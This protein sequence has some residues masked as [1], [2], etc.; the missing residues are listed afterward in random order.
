MRLLNGGMISYHTPVFLKLMFASPCHVKVAISFLDEKPELLYQLDCKTLNLIIQL[1]SKNGMTG[2]ARSI[3]G[4]VQKRGLVINDA[5]YES[6]ILGFCKEKNLKGMWE[7]LELLKQ[8]T[9]VPCT[10]DI[11]VLVNCLCT[12][13]MVKEMFILF[14]NMTEKQPILMQTFFSAILRELNLQ[15]LGNIGC[16]FVEEIYKKNHAFLMDLIKIGCLTS[17]QLS[18]HYL[19][20]LGCIEEALVLKHYLMSRKV[21][22]A[23]S[24]C[25]IL[26]KGFCMVGRIMEAAFQ[27]QEL[28][29]FGMFPDDDTLN[30]L[31]QGFCKV[32][33]LKKA[34]EILGI[35]LRTHAAISI[36]SYRCLVLYCH[37]R[38]FKCSIDLQ[39][40]IQLESTSM[41]LILNNIL[42]FSLFQTDKSFLVNDL[43][44]NMQ[45]KHLIPDSSTYNFLVNGYYKCRNELKAVSI[46]HEM[47]SHGVIPNNRSLKNV[48]HYFC[49]HGKVKEAL[50]VSRMMASHG[51]Q[52]SSSVQCS[53]A[54]GL[55]SHGKISEAQLLLDQL[56]ELRLN[57]KNVYYAPLIKEFCVVG[58][59][60]MAV[61]LLNTMLKKGN[62]PSQSTY[63]TVVNS[64]SIHKAF[65]E[66]LNFHAEMLHKGLEP[67]VVCTD[68]L[69][70]GLLDC[71]RTD[72]ARVILGLML[73]FSIVPTYDMYNFGVKKY[74]AENNI[75][76]ALQLLQEM[77]KA[78]Y[79]P[80]FETRWS[81]IGNL[82]S[83]IQKDDSK[84][85]GF[86][87]SLLS[88]N[89][90]TSKFNKEKGIHII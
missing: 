75:E 74:Y 84:S 88:G 50:E 71:G 55:L 36:S 76:K 8:I 35:L 58:N 72:N 25:K 10:E 38:L 30:V 28:M 82:S 4:S 31:V 61:H 24:L 26:V 81:L 79:S 53:L 69:M 65:D 51:L 49:S 68:T 73:Q 56:E 70:R 23:T 57:P 52:H 17:C 83:S 78:G 15:R 44:D 46:F 89:G 33:N 5:T 29:A 54:M 13:G 85:K 77:Q 43:L 6:V 39:K 48:I 34:F 9:Y 42:I 21:D 80:N 22:H 2:R 7:C 67:S 45:K 40:L 64:F 62:I 19:V 66:A 60:S 16:I 41:G 63:S 86:L 27:L 47:V 87:S 11:K 90:L 14:D 20:N 59:L 1:L 18:L 3:L 12:L 37:Q 32:N